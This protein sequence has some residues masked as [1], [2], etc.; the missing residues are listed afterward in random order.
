MNEADTKVYQEEEDKEDV[1]LSKRRWVPTGRRH[2]DM[3]DAKVC[4]HCVVLSVQSSVG[5]H[6]S[7]ATTYA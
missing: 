1:P 7:N 2:A 3:R 6:R 5:D 4:L